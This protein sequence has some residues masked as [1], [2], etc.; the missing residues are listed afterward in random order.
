MDDRTANHLAAIL[1]LGAIIVS[2][3]AYDASQD[4][5]KLASD[6]NGI[7]TA[8][9]Q[10]SAFQHNQT[11]STAQRLFNLEREHQRPTLSLIR[12]RRTAQTAFVATIQNN[13]LRHCAI[14]SVEYQ[15]HVKYGATGAGG[16][17]TDAPIENVAKT[18]LIDL[19]NITTERSPWELSRPL[20]IEPGGIVTVELTKPKLLSFGEFSLL[21]SEGIATDLGYFDDRPAAPLFEA[22]P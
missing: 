20:T 12:V 11:Q 6:A 7:A 21:S 14:M 9:S 1:A 16:P 2:L 15:S 17:R 22:E 4:A 19:S 3:F 13:G 5:N 10:Q 8:A 18:F